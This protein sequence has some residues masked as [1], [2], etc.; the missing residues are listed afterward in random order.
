M[1]PSPIERK[2]LSGKFSAETSWIAPVCSNA[3]C[4]APEPVEATK[5]C[6]DHTIMLGL[7]QDLPPPAFYCGDCAD[8]I[9]SGRP[10]GEPNVF[11]DI[12]LPISQMEMVCKNEHCRS[13]E[14]TAAVTCFSTECTIY[15]K[16]RPVG[17][18]QQCHRI[19]HTTQRGKDHV[20][21][22]PI[23]APSKMDEDEREGVASAA[24][25]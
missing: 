3:K 9:G 13:V 18:C 21:Q 22:K 15:N 20:L 5:V 6:L 19:K 4:V 2:E 16:N 12:N 25:I 14:K 11:E 8:K 24:L 1:N 7:S 17:Y 10:K 23:S